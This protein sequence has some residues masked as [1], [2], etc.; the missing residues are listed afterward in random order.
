MIKITATMDGK[1]DLSSFAR[2]LKVNIKRSGR[3][4]TQ[5]VTQRTQMLAKMHA[6]VWSGGL[7]SKIAMKVMKDRGEVFISG[8]WIDQAK[9]K[10]NEF[11]VKPHYVDRSNNPLIDQWAIEKGYMYYHNPDVVMV[12]GKGTALGKKNK[13]FQPA[14]MDVQQQLPMIMAKVIRETLM[15]T[16]A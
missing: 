14:F 7:M 8:G 5:K 16:R 11:G 9:A 15:K 12:G 4:L 1:T 3:R 6:P 2:N 13:F 10:A